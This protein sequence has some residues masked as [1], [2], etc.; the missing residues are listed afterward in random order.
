MRPGELYPMAFK[1][2]IVFIGILAISA[3]ITYL[4]KARMERGI[5]YKLWL[6]LNGFFFGNFII[7]LFVMFFMY[8]EVPILSA[9]FWFLTWLIGICVW[10][11]FIIKIALK[12]PDQKKQHAEEKEF[13]KYIP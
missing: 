7:G 10:L 13:K 2:L 11:Y 6:K 8:E 9:R 1:I 12:I 3:F 5:Y 4:I